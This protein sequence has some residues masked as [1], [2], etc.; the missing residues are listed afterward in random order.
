MKILI[1]DT[2]AINNNLYIIESLY[3]AFKKNK[4]FKKVEWASYNNFFNKASTNEWDILVAVGGA[5]AD[6]SFL[7]R[8]I[9]Y[10][11]FSILWTTEDPYELT[12]NVRVA[13]LFNYVF[14]NEERSVPAYK[15]NNILNCSYLPLAGDERKKLVPVEDESYFLYDVFFLGT[16]WPNRMAYLKDV[17]S[18][19]SRHYR[20]KFG[21]SYNEHLPNAESIENGLL[22]DWRASNDE[23]IKMM[24]RSKVTIGLPREFSGSE[25]DIAKSYSPPPRVFEAG[26]AGTALVYVDGKNADLNQ[27]FIRDVDYK[28]VKSSKNLASAIKR[29]CSSMTERLSL[30]QSLQNKVLENHT[31]TN[32]VNNIVDV[33]KTNFKDEKKIGTKKNYKTINVLMITHNVIGDNNW[34]GVEVYQESLNGMENVNL[35]FLWKKGNKIYVRNSDKIIESYEL[36]GAQEVDHWI[37]DREIE[38]KIAKILTVYNV[39][40][41]HFQH[42]LGLPISLMPY[43]KK[44]GYKVIFMIHDYFSICHRFNLL[45]F[46][47]KYCGGGSEGQ[48]KICCEADALDQN[49]IRRRRS[50]FQIALNSCDLVMF[51][52]KTAQDLHRLIFNFDSINTIILP[53]PV[54][55]VKAI[56]ASYETYDINTIVSKDASY[57]N[58]KLTVIIIGNF[59]SE[60]GAD[61]LIRIFNA[62]RED[63]VM[64]RVAGRISEEYSNIILKT[65]SLTNVEILGG[66]QQDNIDKILK[67]VDIAVFLPTW[68]E[69]YMMTVDEVLC[70]GIPVI[71]NKLGAPVERVVDGVH[72][73]VL[74]DLLPGTLFL[75]LKMILSNRPVIFDLK[76]KLKLN[77]IHTSPY[78]NR[79]KVARLYRDLNIKQYNNEIICDP[80]DDIKFDLKELGIIRNNIDFSNKIINIQKLPNSY[81]PIKLI[82]ESALKKVSDFKASLSHRHLIDSYD[83]EYNAFI[84]MLTELDPTNFKDLI[85][86]SLKNLIGHVDTINDQQIF[87]NYNFYYNQSITINGWISTLD[88]ASS[89]D[90]IYIVVSQLG[91]K[92]FA[93]KAARV[94]RD[95]VALSYSNIS[96][97]ECGFH[98]SFEFP[99]FDSFDLVNIFL[100][101]KSSAE[102]SLGSWNAKYICEARLGAK[103]GV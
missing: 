51:G 61:D 65:L 47:K 68:P 10:F 66:Y 28:N 90:L 38:I 44:I 60:K 46:N 70:Y 5:G 4:I 27:S 58:K 35:L 72:G 18:G 24:S 15:K 31:Y 48:C 6:F 62:C 95:D 97:L 73:Y 94:E 85:V 20:I 91:K 16:V 67:D 86:K 59:T 71:I 26:I 88:Q 49:T 102:N 69:T 41:V 9:P 56:D 75:K 55:S 99:K 40:I 52:S 103:P 22:T 13:K 87:D 33:I 84:T 77:P 34:G 78:E 54:C 2:A 100:F 57:E 17:A 93:F 96:L 98:V 30:A 45:D 23:Y 76:R 21:C 7:Q 42:L 89:K 14:T 32:R 79:K 63:S 37:S 50:F 1:F 8:C 92:F 74:E 39:D 43:V 64:F 29:I 3:Y 83:H 25:N 53:F 12:R 101:C 81:Y 36:Q 82:N 80:G 11:S 19:L